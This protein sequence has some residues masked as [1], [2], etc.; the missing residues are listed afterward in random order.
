MKKSI[1]LFLTLLSTLSL[2]AGGSNSFELDFKNDLIISLTSLGIWGT[3]FYLTET[4]DVDIDEP[5]G[6]PDEKYARE[7]SEFN[8]ELG[9]F[10]V[11]STTLALPFL[12]DQWESSSVTT[13]GVMYLESFS[14]LYGTKNILKSLIVRPRPYNFIETTGEDEEERLE[15]LEENDRFFSFPS[16]HTA[17]AFMTATFSTYVYSRGNSSMKSKYI[18]GAASYSLAIASAF[19]RVEAGVHYPIDLSAGALLGCGVGLL[20]PALHL[21][22]PEHCDL[23]LNGDCLCI[24]I[25]I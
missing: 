10:L 25:Y 20:I 16:G 15:E 19:A 3:G 11:C 4:S 12:L 18:M 17:I 6:W 24:S 22:M 9:D 5:L 1:I 23:V 2:Y 14:L 7:F 13:L 8:D 21:K